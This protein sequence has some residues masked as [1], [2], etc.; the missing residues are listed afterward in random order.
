[1]LYDSE[2]VTMPGK[3]KKLKNRKKGKTL[4]EQEKIVIIFGIKAIRW[5]S[6]PGWV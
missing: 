4:L 6:D 5:K 2:A 3:T 1:M